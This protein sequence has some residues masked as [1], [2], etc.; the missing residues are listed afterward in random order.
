MTGPIPAFDT[1]S[2]ASG[3][4]LLIIELQL[5]LLW[6]LNAD[7]LRMCPALWAFFCFNSAAVWVAITWFLS[8]MINSASGSSVELDPGMYGNWGVSTGNAISAE[9]APLRSTSRSR[10]IQQDKYHV[11]E[12]LRFTR[13]AKRYRKWAR[14]DSWSLAMRDSRGNDP[15]ERS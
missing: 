10:T 1:T 11:Y 7:S 6:V 2:P 5:V 9:L 4:L 13:M 8:S 12:N 14:D 3:P 15:T